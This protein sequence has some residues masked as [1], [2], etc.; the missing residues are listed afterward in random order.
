MEKLRKNKGITLVALVITIV[1]LIILASVVINIAIKNG[2]IL[3][4]AKDAKERY[5]EAQALETMTANIAEARMEA[6]TMQEGN[7]LYKIAKGLENNN[8]V[9]SVEKTSVRGASID[10]DDA[11]TIETI[12]VILRNYYFEFV[13][14]ENGKI[15]NYYKIDEKQTTLTSY[16][17]TYELNEGTVSSPNPATYTIETDTFTLINPTKEGYVFDGW[18]EP[19]SEEKQTTVTIEKGTTGNKTF[20]ANWKE[21]LYIIQNGSV[22]SGYSL[23]QSAHGIASKTKVSPTLSGT[24]MSVG[25]EQE[26]FVYVS[27]AINA[28]NY[29][30]IS[31]TYSNSTTSIYSQRR[32]FLYDNPN[33]N[34]P[35]TYGGIMPSSGNT[36][37]ITS[38]TGNKYI[39]FWLYYGYTLTISELYVEE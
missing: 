2:G 38:Y 39:T 20:I 26:G 30:K 7:I 6:E 32:L 34:N 18:T 36:S 15:E 8:D 13:I 24:T 10:F 12:Y 37:D 35:D 29:S 22:K 5:D 27:P 28:S 17:I 1:V 31:V 21:R 23:V 19:G 14:V 25:E 4:R 33:V 3:S 9:L 16:N 11:N